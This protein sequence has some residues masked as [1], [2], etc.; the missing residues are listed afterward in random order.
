MDSSK[1]LFLKVSGDWNAFNAKQNFDLLSPVIESLIRNFCEYSQYFEHVERDTRLGPSTV[2]G[3]IAM[4]Y[5]IDTLGR[6][7]VTPLQAARVIMVSSV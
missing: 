5:N 2:T 4:R 6:S 3:H 1:A 7:E